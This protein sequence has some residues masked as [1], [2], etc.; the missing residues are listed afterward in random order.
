[1][2][3]FIGGVLAVIVHLVLPLIIVLYI[4]FG[5]EED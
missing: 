1:M 3:K 5:R 4:I 2:I